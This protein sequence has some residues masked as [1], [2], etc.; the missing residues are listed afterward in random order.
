MLRLLIAIAMAAGLAACATTPNPL[1]AT[2]RGAF[3]VKDAAVIWAV[4][5]AKLAGK[6]SYEAAKADLQARLKVAVEKEFADSP[7]GAEAVEFA[8]KVNKYN[9]STFVR[10]DVDVVRKSDGQVLATYKDVV[11]MH[12]N[13]GGL[14]GALIEAAMKPDYVAI[15]TNGFAANLRMRFESKS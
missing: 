8:V 5:D 2:V 10:A 13:N 12:V 4:D 11:G 1:T 9:G 6:E 15:I 7:S 3:F 14:V